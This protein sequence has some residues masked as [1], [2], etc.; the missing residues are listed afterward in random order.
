VPYPRRDRASVPAHTR[1][2]CCSCDNTAHTDSGGR[3]VPGRAVLLDWD[4]TLADTRERNYRSLRDAL[5]PYQV[6]VTFEW[7]DQRRR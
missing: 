4:G 7:Y 6:T 3:P 5:A 1:H 2:P